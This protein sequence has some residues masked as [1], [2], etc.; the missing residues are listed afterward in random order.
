MDNVQLTINGS[1]IIYQCNAP[2]CKISSFWCY[3]SVFI[4]LL[5]FSSIHPVAC[6]VISLFA[7]ILSKILATRVVKKE[8]YKIAIYQHGVYY[9]KLSKPPKFISRSSIK[10]IFI[11][12]YLVD[13]VTSFDCPYCIEIKTDHERLFFFKNAPKSSLEK[14]LKALQN[15]LK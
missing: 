1:E 4:L 5:Q 14:S 9:S 3:L 7:T 2:I 10:T 11:N 13:H 12:Q 15:I 6:L 8:V